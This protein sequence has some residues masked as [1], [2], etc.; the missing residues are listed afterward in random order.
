MWRFRLTIQSKMDLNPSMLTIIVYP[1]SMSYGSI[2]KRNINFWWILSLEGNSAAKFDSNVV[3]IRI[4]KLWIV[5]RIK[6][7]NKDLVVATCI[8]END[9]PRP[10]SSNGKL[11]WHSN[12]SEAI[13]TTSSLVGNWP[14]NGSGSE[15]EREGGLERS[16]GFG[17]WV[18][19]ANRR[20]VDGLACFVFRINS[21]W[22][23]IRDLNDTI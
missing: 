2:V 23:C 10:W 1:S 7:H 22:W 9:E 14:I 12:K 17:K 13:A 20:S 4:T 16:W 3:L 6:L 8:V 5:T 18:K 19:E 11:M 15:F 21:W